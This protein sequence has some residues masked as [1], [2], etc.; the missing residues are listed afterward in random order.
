MP[1]DEMQIQPF[2]VLQT[3]QKAA[4]VMDTSPPKFYNIVMSQ[5]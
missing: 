1:A 3:I 4:T 2:F 5:S